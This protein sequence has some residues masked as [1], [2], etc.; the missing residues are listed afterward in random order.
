MPGVNDSSILTD[1]KAALGLA[2]DYTDFDTELVLHI[3]SVLAEVA[4]L[5]VGPKTGYQI[6]SKEN[7]WSEL[8]GTEKRLNL[9]KSFVYDS[10]KLIFDPDQIG[11]VL[12][13]KKELLQKAAFRIEVVCEEIR[14]EELLAAGLTP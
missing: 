10:V 3:N 5:G 4:Q 13:A 11:F 2:D 12:T 7:K 9:V 14:K 6:E 8:L 1:T